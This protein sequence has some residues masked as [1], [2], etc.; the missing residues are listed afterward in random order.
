MMNVWLLR[1]LLA[2][3]TARTSEASAGGVRGT[4]SRCEGLQEE[5]LYRQVPRGVP[6][7]AGT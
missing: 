6:T 7:T 4:A 3:G 2:A 5:D 1:L